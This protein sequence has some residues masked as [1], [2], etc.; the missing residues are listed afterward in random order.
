MTILLELLWSLAAVGLA[1]YLGLALTRQTP[2]EYPERV[3]PL[4]FLTATVHW[5]GHN[6]D[7]PVLLY[8]PAGLLLM[9]VIRLAFHT[10]VLYSWA[11]AALSLTA[12]ETIELQRLAKVPPVIALALLLLPSVFARQ[13]M[14]LL[15]EETGLELTGE[16][17]RAVRFDLHM[18]SIL[19]ALAAVQVWLC[20]LLAAGDHLASGTLWTLLAASAVLCGLLLLFVRLVS[21]DTVHRVEAVVDKQYQKELLNL[22][23]VIRAQRHDFNSHI[24]ALAGMLDQKNYDEFH[25]YLTQMLQ[26][27]YTMN[28]ILPLHSPAVSAMLNSFRE[29]AVQK[30]I[31]MEVSVTDSLEH[32]PC[33]VYE[34][35]TVIS[36]L[37]QNAVDEVEGKPKGWIKVS[38]LKRGGKHIVKVTNPCEA[39]PEDISQMFQPGYSTKKSHS[40]IGLATVERIVTRCGGSVYPEWKDG[41]LSMIVKLPAFQKYE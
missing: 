18:G 11:T 25:A 7:L 35:N 19:A 32:I 29:M 39:S 8:I 15:P 16:Q 36:N 23:Q 41:T 4:W 31:A 30:R 22:M 3:L 24:Q 5:A 38:I 20:G 33:T 9:G 17:R 14:T 12:L 27:T 1:L 26:L 40:G 28:D 21:F 37:L 34:I 10:S 6:A 2:E 13:G